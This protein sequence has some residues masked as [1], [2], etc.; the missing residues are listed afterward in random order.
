MLKP[1][2]EQVVCDECNST[3]IVQDLESGELIC[4]NCGY[5]ISTI[6]MDPSPE[7]KAFNYNQGDTGSRVGAPAKLSIHDMGLSTTMGWQ[8]K[9]HTGRNLSPEE[10]DKIYRLRKWDKRSK[11]SGSSDRN[12]A[13]ALSSI[14]MICSKLNLP[15]N[16]VET[17]SLL[18]RIVLNGV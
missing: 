16:I 13:Y 14:T 12:L 1:K 3:I 11:K 7:W 10:R 5:V 17:S 6:M 18:Y 4:K 9:D 8:N 2:L 15:K